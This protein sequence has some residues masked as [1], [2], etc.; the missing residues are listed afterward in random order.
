MSI[1]KYSPPRGRY[2]HKT[3][4]EALVG[5]IEIDTLKED[6]MIVHIEIN[7]DVTGN[8]ITI[9]YVCTLFKKNN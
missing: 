1:K 7:L 5:A 2:V 4:L 8:I 6:Q 3:R 9:L